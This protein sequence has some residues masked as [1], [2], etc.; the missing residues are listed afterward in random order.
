MLTNTCS[1]DLS[2]RCTSAFAEG[3][4]ITLLLLL[5]TQ[6]YGMVSKKLRSLLKIQV[7]YYGGKIRRMNDSQHLTFGNKTNGNYRLLI[8][9]S[10][11]THEVASF[12][13]RAIS[14]ECLII[15]FTP[16]TATLLSRATHKPT[17]KSPLKT[18]ECIS[19]CSVW[20]KPF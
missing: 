3:C 18:A 9:M 15:F 20:I 4:V 6:F 5:L 10:V 17:S 8:P 11:H 7:L 14:L 13:C 2:N 19:F 16:V 12:L 1:S